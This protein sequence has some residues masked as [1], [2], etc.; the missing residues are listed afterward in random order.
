VKECRGRI[1][2]RRRHATPHH[3]TAVARINHPLTC[4]D[5]AV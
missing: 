3:P 5:P 4:S 1:R 2:D